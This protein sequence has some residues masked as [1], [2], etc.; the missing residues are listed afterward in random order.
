M[1]CRPLCRLTRLNSSQY[2]GQLQ[3]YIYFFFPPDNNKLKVK[4]DVQKE[5]INSIGFEYELISDGIRK[6]YSMDEEN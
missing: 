1:E 3:E 2:S 6:N 4:N 5:I